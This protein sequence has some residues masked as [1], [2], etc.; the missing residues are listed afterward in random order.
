[1]GVVFSVS[2]CE[3]VSHCACPTSGT[4]VDAKVLLCL[5]RL[6]G[7]KGDLTVRDVPGVKD[8]IYNL[9]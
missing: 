8:I 3:L 5:S 2:C 7:V 9:L 6:R 1:M 4:R